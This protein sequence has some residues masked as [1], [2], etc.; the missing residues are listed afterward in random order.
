MGGLACSSPPSPPPSDASLVAEFQSRRSDY[1][2]LL[3][4]FREDSALGRVAYDFTRSAS[5]FSGAPLRPS[6]PLTEGRLRE[7]R[8]LFDRLSLPGGIEGY[9]SKH[10]V[11]FWRYSEGMGAGLGG[12]SQGFAYSDSLPPEKP[13]ATGCAKPDDD[14]WQFRPIGAGWFILEERHN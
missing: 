7:Y 14:C 3:S 4:M 2:R 9:D 1:E 6:G 5:F 12:S 13:S 8:Q 11:Y 10:V